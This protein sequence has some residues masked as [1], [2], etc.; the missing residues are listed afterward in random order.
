MKIDIRFPFTIVKTDYLEKMEREFERCRFTIEKEKVGIEKEKVGIEKRKEELERSY[1]Q[2]ARHIILES[3]CK[4]CR[5]YV[6]PGEGIFGA[7]GKEES[8]RW[9]GKCW[10]KKVSASKK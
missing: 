6:P 4:G 3:I 10:N 1:H 2:Q 5:M 9:C 8:A 7:V